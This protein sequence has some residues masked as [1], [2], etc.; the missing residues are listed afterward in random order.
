MNV[1]VRLGSYQKLS[2]YYKPVVSIDQGH[3]EQIGVISVMAWTRI[4]LIRKSTVYL[5]LKKS[6][7]EE[8]NIEEFD[9]LGWTY[10]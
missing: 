2:I 7:S 1:Q 3:P 9:Q 5:K 8:L 10:D 6:V 4:R